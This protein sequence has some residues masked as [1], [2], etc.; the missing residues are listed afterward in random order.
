MA[1]YPYPTET[2]VEFNA[3]DWLNQATANLAIT[4]SEADARYIFKTQSDT[5]TGQIT[6]T[7]GI[8]TNS[9][10]S[11]TGIL[12]IGNSGTANTIGF[13]STNSNLTVLGNILTIGQS[14][15]NVS[16]LGNIFRIG[17]SN[18]NV[19]ILGNIFSIGQSNSNVSVFGNVLGIGQ[20]NS[21]VSVSGLITLTT[22]D[23]SEG[24]GLILT[25]NSLLS[26]NAG[27]SSGMHLCLT[28]GSTIYKIKL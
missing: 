22:R 28:I 3:L 27:G 10:Q 5:A 23:G 20:S 19:S 13:G 1:T 4:Q 21:N 9:L 24:S 12:N 18:S 15:S 6:F 2:D 16:V 17:Q 25:G 7:N 26:A 14:N 11:Y 8:V